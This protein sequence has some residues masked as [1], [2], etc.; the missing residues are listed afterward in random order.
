[1]HFIHSYTD[2]DDNEGEDCVLY[3]NRTLLFNVILFLDYPNNFYTEIIHE[4]NS[5]LTKSVSKLSKLV[6]LTPMTRSYH[7]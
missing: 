7:L 4:L 1:M 6:G 2:F 3:L 5:L